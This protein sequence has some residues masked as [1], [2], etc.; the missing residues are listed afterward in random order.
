[1]FFYRV[2]DHPP[3]EGVA[4]GVNLQQGKIIVGRGEEALAVDIPDPFQGEL[5]I[6]EAERY[7][8]I[9]VLHAPIDNQEV[10]LA[11]IACHRAP[12]HLR[13]EGRFGMLD[14]QLVQVDL[15]PREILCRGREPRVNIAREIEFQLRKL[16]AVEIKVVR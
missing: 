11:E 10:P 7:S 2:G 8:V 6:D 3:D 12:F 9:R 14:Q 1:M 16:R 15:L 13:V 5:A 4:F